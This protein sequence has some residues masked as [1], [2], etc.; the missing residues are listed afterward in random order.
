MKAR[1][2]VSV[3]SF[4]SQV[5]WWYVNGIQLAKVELLI[6]RTSS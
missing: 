3:D 5:L 1:E 4:I 2:T 6:D